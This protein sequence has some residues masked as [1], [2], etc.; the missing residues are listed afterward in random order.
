MLMTKKRKAK[1]AEERERHS[2]ELAALDITIRALMVRLGFEKLELPAEETRNVLSRPLH[3]HIHED[4]SVT[5]TLENG[6][7]E[8]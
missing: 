1:L 3:V 5:L 8:G 2:R 6:N 4:L 7:A